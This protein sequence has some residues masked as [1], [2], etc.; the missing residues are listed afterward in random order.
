MSYKQT[1]AGLYSVLLHVNKIFIYD[2]SESYA[3]LKNDGWI[4]EIIYE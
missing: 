1:K 3:K 2:F 4:D